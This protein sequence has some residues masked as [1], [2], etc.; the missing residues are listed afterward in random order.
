[1]AGLITTV[2][3]SI[4]FVAFLTALN[5]NKRAEAQT[6]RR[7]DL[8]RAFD[9]ISNEIRMASRINQTATMDIDGATPLA[10]VITSS[11][12]NLSDLGSYGTLV[13]YLEIPIANVP[14]TCADG[15][16]P[17]APA[18][19]D[20][21]VYDI[22]DS[23]SDWLPPRSINRYGR[24]P[25]LDGSIDPCSDPVSSDILVDA[26]ND[27]VSSV[28]SC[29]TPAVLTGTEGFH[30]CVEGAQVAL[31]FESSVVGTEVHELTSNVSSRLTDNSDMTPVLS[32]TRLSGTDTMDLSWTWT[33]PIATFK[34]FQSVAG[35]A[36]TEIYSGSDLSTTH[37]LTGSSGDE[38][39]YTVTATAGLDTSPASNQICEMK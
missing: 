25:K 17:P 9:F 20:R 33:G 5:A 16:A 34:V 1:V 27:S 18:E 21:V 39:C 24:I 23:G 29:T 7:T 15:S 6:R 35:G 31:Y 11:G 26:I 22:R 13:L 10:D 36:A 37:I 12:L 28:P 38:T 32:G 4:L 30:S 8:S 19:Y 3:V 14:D 2:V